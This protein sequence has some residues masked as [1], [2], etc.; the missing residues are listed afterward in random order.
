MKKKGAYLG[1]ECHGKWW[2]RYTKKGYFIRGNGTYW[3]GKNG[4]YFQRCLTTIPIYIPYKDMQDVRLGQR[5]SG[6]YVILK[7]VVKIYWKC[8]KDKLCSGFLMDNPV[9]TRNSLCRKIRK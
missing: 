5:H 4:I 6:R 9:R 7:K 2:K 1:T 8:G 3:N